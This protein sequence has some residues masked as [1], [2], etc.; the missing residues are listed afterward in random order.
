MIYNL[1]PKFQWRREEFSFDG[2]RYLDERG[3]MDLTN[4]S[5][6]LAKYTSDFRE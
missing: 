2:L 6:L 1:F 5:E 4:D 3:D